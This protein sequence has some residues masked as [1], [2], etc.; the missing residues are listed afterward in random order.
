MAILQPY[1]LTSEPSI[2]LSLEN[3]DFIETSQYKFVIPFINA[4][5]KSLCSKDK[6]FCSKYLDSTKWLL[7]KGQLFIDPNHINEKG[8]EIIVKEIISRK[9]D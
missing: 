8:N 2:N 4:E 6:D 5:V 7:N 1:L 3:Q 9:L